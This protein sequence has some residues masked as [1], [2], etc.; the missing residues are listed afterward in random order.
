MISPNA[1]SFVSVS[2]ISD[3]AKIPMQRFHFS[4]FC[5]HCKAGFVTSFYLFWSPVI[6]AMASCTYPTGR[7]DNAKIDLA[8]LDVS[9]EHITTTTALFSGMLN[10]NPA[11]QGLGLIWR[12]CSTDV[13]IKAVTSTL[14]LFLSLINYIAD[15]SGVAARLD[16]Q[17]NWVSPSCYSIG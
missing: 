11:T 3:I 1:G 10:I 4:I 9:K 5:V 14:S 2:A 13:D 15:E 8:V 6:R 16:W 17:I 7:A 12:T